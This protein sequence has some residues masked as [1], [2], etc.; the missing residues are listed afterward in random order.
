MTWELVRNV[1]SWTPHTSKVNFFFFFQNLV[2]E[3]S[4]REFGKK[5]NNNTSSSVFWIIKWRWLRYILSNKLPG[6]ANATHHRPHFVLVRQEEAKKWYLSTWLIFL[7]MNTDLNKRE[8]ERDISLYLFP[9]IITTLECS[10]KQLSS[11]TL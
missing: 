2:L 4:H 3:V 9:N 8:V 5:Q 6:D 11:S 1:K 10:K 7:R